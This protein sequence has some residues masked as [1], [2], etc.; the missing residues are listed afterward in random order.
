M[1]DSEVARILARMLDGIRP[2]QEQPRGRPLQRFLG[3]D[4]SVSLR[5]PELVETA[6]EERYRFDGANAKFGTAKFMSDVAITITL[7]TGTFK[8]NG[9]GSRFGLAK[10]A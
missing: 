10:F 1:A 5:E 9:A 3:V 8:F 6:S 4:E 2:A 7:R